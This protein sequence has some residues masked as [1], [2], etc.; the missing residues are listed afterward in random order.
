MQFLH[1]EWVVGI[2]AGI[3][4]AIIMSFVSQILVKKR[5]TIEHLQQIKLAN[6]EVIDLLTPYIADKGLP[7]EKIITA[8]INSVARKY[9]IYSYEMYSLDFFC[10]EII[11]SIIGNVYISNEQKE[12]YTKE[13]IEYTER[14]DV[15]SSSD[16]EENIYEQILMRQV[17]ELKLNKKYN[18]IY[19]F[20]M[21][22]ITLVLTTISVIKNNYRI[23]VY[24]FDQ[25][26]WLLVLEFVLFFILAII[27]FKRYRK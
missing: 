13:L 24:P 9:K 8:I 23:L 7:D 25:Y 17:Y 18:Y 6:A 11:K 1:N 10:E 14:R 27:V 15:T 19:S 4:S 20:S 5:E 26:P 3:I 22:F 16:D 21:V 12:K 2:G